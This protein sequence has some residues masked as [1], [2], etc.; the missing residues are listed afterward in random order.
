MIRAY[1]LMVVLR[2]D[3]DV[4]SAQKRESLVKKLLGETKVN[5]TSSFG[6][7]TLAYPIQKQTEAVY[8]LAHIEADKVNVGEV[9]KRAK[10]EQ[11]VLR[12]LL[13]L[14]EPAFAST[15]AKATVDK[16]ATAGK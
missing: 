16:K 15:I 8:L 1:E 9:E 11:S 13:T 5:D 7:K 10:L 2:P 6:K 4:D 3:F 12:F 14:K